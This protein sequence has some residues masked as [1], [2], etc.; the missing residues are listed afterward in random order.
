MEVSSMARRIKSSSA[1]AKAAGIKF[2][3][4]K[5]P[6]TNRKVSGVEKKGAGSRG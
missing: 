2:S 4:K 5:F 1:A 6:A 3:N